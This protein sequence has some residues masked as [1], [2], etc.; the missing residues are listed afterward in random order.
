MYLYNDLVIVLGSAE[1]SDSPNAEVY[2]YYCCSETY[3]FVTVFKIGTADK[4]PEFIDTY[5]QEGSFHDV[6]ITPDNILYLI[7]KGF[8]LEKYD[9]S[10]YEDDYDYDD[11]IGQ[12]NYH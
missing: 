10:Y 8:S 5:F 3:S 4:A 9:G 7:S 12:Q 11:D 6:R 2:N 1:F